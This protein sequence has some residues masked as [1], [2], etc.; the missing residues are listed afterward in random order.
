MQ[1]ASN[2][3][4]AQNA[5]YLSPEEQAFYQKKVEVIQELLMKERQGRTAEEQRD[6]EEHLKEL[7]VFKL[8]LGGQQQE[9]RTGEI[10]DKDPK[11]YKLNMNPVYTGK[12]PSRNKRNI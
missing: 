10:K 9:L 1:P 3:A 5:F 4:M 11:N 6:L 7:E 12:D 8:N 2:T